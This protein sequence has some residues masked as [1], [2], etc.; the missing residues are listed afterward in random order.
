MRMKKMSW[1]WMM[2]AMR[3]SHS[4]S[5]F[6]S[7]KVREINNLFKSF[8]NFFSLID[9]KAAHVEQAKRIAVLEARVQALDKVADETTRTSQRLDA[10]EGQVH[11][12]T[13]ALESFLGRISI[14]DRL[15]LVPDT[16]RIG[17]RR[18]PAL[19]A[20]P[21]RSTSPSTPLYLDIPMEEDDA[22]SGIQ[23]VAATRTTRSDCQQDI[24]MVEVEPSAMSSES[25]HI[26]AH[27]PAHNIVAPVPAPPPASVNNPVPVPAPTVGPAP[28]PTF[29]L[30]PATPQGSQV[31]AVPTPTPPV[32]PR[33]TPPPTAAGEE[34]PA[35]SKVPRGRSR[36]PAI[37]TSRLAV[38]DGP[39]TRSRSR[40]ATPI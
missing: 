17:D 25:H 8:F 13:G 24:R 38:R 28:P 10:M 3:E 26:P 30:I 39:T 22:G 33:H 5:G 6:G 36:T 1:W 31:F 34:P 15:R 32:P 4:R 35:P 9:F 23:S 12:F 21:T 29:N 18:S 19:L 37:N 27:V 11:R 20:G 14:D 2:T 7:Q 40:S 16:R